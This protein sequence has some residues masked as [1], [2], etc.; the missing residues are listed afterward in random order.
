[1]DLVEA[2]IEFLEMRQFGKVLKISDIA[3]SDRH[4]FQLLVCGKQRGY[5]GQKELK[6]D[7]LEIQLFLVLPF[8]VLN[9]KSLLDDRNVS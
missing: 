7:V 1:L 9:I 6:P 2:K 3:M 8:G 4:V 5:L